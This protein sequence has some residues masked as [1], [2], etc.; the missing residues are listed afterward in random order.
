MNRYFMTIPEAVNLVLQAATMGS[1]GEVFVLNMGEQIKIVDLAND[2]ISL[3][4]LEPEKDV[5]IVFTGVRPGEKLSEELWDNLTNVRRTEHTE[6]RQMLHEESDNS[7]ELQDAVS[8]LIRL[9]EEGDTAAILKLLDLV[10]P[11]ASV[12]ST[13]RPDLISIS[14]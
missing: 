3:S 13:P 9:A 11:G 6:I 12:S 8:E 4:G 7:K 2:L 14:S 5:E 10:V 1:G